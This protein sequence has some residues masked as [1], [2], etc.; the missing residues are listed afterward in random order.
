MFVYL[1]AP[2]SSETASAA[3]APPSLTYSIQD[4]AAYWDQRPVA[5]GRRLAVVAFEAARWGIGQGPILQKALSPSSAMRKI[6]VATI[7]FV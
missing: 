5:V 7:V 3:D 6:C 4:A 1:S 2:R